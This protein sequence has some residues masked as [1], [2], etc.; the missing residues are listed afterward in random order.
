MEIN[1]VYCGVSIL[2][3]SV[4][5]L[6]TDVSVKYDIWQFMF[7]FISDTNC[8]QIYV[9]QNIALSGTLNNF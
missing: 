7:H 9:L 8:L 1:L 4:S 3:L 6:V 2:S 5:L